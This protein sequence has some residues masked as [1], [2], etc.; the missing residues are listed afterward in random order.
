MGSNGRDDEIQRLQFK[1]PPPPVLLSVGADVSSMLTAI[2]RGLKSLN[3]GT[4]RETEPFPN[5]AFSFA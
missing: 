1:G 4:L 3:D 2:G 5:L